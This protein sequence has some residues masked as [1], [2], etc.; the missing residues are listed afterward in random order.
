MRVLMTTMGLEIGGAETHILEAAK[1]LKDRG[2]EVTVMSNGG[3]YA[4]E[5]ENY[6]IR[7]IWAPMHSKKT[8]VRKKS[9][10]DIKRLTGQRAL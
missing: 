6:G 1:A 7:H 9:L 3:V 4:K 10:R 8:V 2:V 5:L